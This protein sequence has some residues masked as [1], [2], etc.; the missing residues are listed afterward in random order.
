MSLL[1]QSEVLVVC[2]DVMRAVDVAVNHQFALPMDVLAHL[3]SCQTDVYRARF[4][5]TSGPVEMM[6]SIRKVLDQYLRAASK[7]RRELEKEME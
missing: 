6:P 7:L 1:S 3:V 2:E 4:S 5:A